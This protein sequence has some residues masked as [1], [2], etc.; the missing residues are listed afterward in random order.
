[1]ECLGYRDAGDVM[2]FIDGMFGTR[3]LL[4]SPDTGEAIHPL[5]LWEDF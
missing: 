2:V 4:D 3:V 5:P 1:M